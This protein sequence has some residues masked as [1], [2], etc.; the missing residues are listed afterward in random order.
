MNNLELKVEPGDKIRLKTGNFAGSRGI[1]EATEEG[2]LVI[3]LEN[4]IRRVLAEP[5]E[6]LNFSVAARKAWRSMPKRRVGRPK[7]M[8][9]CD[10]V[11]VTLRIDRDLWE[12]FRSKESTG[13]IDDRTATVNAWLREKL[14]ELDQVERRD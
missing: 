1:V 6:V 5:W 4:S 2:K 7:G 3:R 14:A 11:S 9:S 12:Q 13:I 10:R 8:R